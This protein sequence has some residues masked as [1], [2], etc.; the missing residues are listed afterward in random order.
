MMT[1][2]PEFHLLLLLFPSKNMRIN[3]FNEIKVTM[4]DQ[5]QYKTLFIFFFFFCFQKKILLLLLLLQIL[6]TTACL[7][8]TLSWQI[9]DNE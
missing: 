7:K 3:D 6:M 9:I 5:I 2:S 8:P 1:R 4:T